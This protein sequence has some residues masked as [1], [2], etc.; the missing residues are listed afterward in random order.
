MEHRQ[1]RTGREEDSVRLFKEFL[2]IKTISQEGHKGPNQEAVNF[3]RTHLEQL[4]LQTKVVEC[5]QGKP[6]LIATLLGE[7]PSLPSICLNSHY[8]VVP[9]VDRM[10]KVDPWAAAEDEEGNIFGRG[11]QDMKCVCIQYILALQQLLGKGEKFKRTIHLTFVPDEEVGGVEGMKEFVLTDDFKSL[12]IAVALDEGL[13]NPTDKFT[14]FY[15]ERAVWWLKVKSS[16]PTG[17]GSRFIKNTAMEK[18][19]RS[20]QQF[21]A[22]RAE[23]EARLEAHPG[24]QHAAVKAEK[25]GDVVTLNLTMLQGGVSSD[26][27]KTW[28]LNVIPTE[29]EAGFDVRIPP[30][31]PLDEFEANLKEWTKE[32]GVEYEFVVK[33]PK[34]SVSSINVNES[35]WWRVFSETMQN[36]NLEIETEIFPAAT[37]SRYL[38]QVGIPAFGFSPM[39]RTPILLHDHNEFLSAKVFLGGVPIYVS[40]IKAL[41]GH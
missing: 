18:L 14:V 17:H 27:G 25:L 10:W 22:F 4:G 13:A 20:V 24:C 9:A 31:V 6:I 34:H 39:N 29:A 1:P 2:R 21:L 38:R 32:E 40:L 36:L 12:N 16:G 5:I 35:E 37:D 33:T 15:G 11:T 28:A 8:D 3:L 26:G 19:L 7:Q 41:A 30:T 23:Q